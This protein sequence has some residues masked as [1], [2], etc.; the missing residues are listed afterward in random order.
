MSEIKLSVSVKDLS[1]PAL[2][3]ELAKAT[4]PPDGA[5]PSDVDAV[6]A[7]VDQAVELAALYKL[8][9]PGTVEFFH[10]PA[11]NSQVAVT[12]TTGPA[13]GQ[14]LDRSKVAAKAAA[15]TRAK[16][17]A[18]RA[19]ARKKVVELPKSPTVA[20]PA[21]PAIRPPGAKSPPP[22]P[23]RAALPATRPTTPPPPRRS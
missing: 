2:A 16:A 9:G 6:A 14:G 7:L 20:A 11:G 13:H 12:P 1:S 21:P 10:D 4:A 19:A 22:P 23:G 17:A 15:R 3:V 18:D 5:A 8:T